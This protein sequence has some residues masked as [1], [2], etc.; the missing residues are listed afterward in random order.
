MNCMKRTPSNQDFFHLFQIEIR[1]PFKGHRS[2]NC[3]ILDIG[4]MK[5][6]SIAVLYI[7]EVTFQA[8]SQFINPLS[9]IS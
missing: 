5:G 9:T 7:L 8:L 3:K 2:V 4:I 1:G 6:N